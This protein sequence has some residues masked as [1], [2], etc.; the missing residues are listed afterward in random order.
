M[1]SSSKGGWRGLSWLHG[2]VR[3]SKPRRRRP[4]R[5]TAS[6][7]TPPAVPILLRKPEQR[8]R[9]EAWGFLAMWRGCKRLCADGL[10]GVSEAGPAPLAWPPRSA[11]QLPRR[12]HQM[13]ADALRSRLWEGEH[14]GVGA[15]TCGGHLRC[16]LRSQTAS[17]GRRRGLRG[18]RPLARAARECALTPFQVLPP[19]PHA[20][21]AR[22][23]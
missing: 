14:G 9:A 4:L 17:S 8:G 20:V 16:D 19:P 21:R 13:A 12:R 3:T 18:P 2:Q 15:P 10:G 23:C 7:G 11:R 1:K 22:T 5:H 6:P